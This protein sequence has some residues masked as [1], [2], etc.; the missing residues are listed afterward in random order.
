[1]AKT[2]VLA[3]AGHAH[4][5]ILANI[6]EI[7]KKGHQVLV[8]GPSPH[9]YYSGMGPGMLGGAYEPDDIRF[10]V[11]DMVESS[12]GVFLQ[13]QVARI[14]PRK[15][16]LLLKSGE[17]VD[18]DVVTFNTGSYV[19]SVAEE[20]SHN[21]F[22]VKPIENLSLGR[23]RILD[24][25]RDRQVRIGVVGGGPAGL[26][27]AGNSW[28]ASHENNGKG[29]SIR[30]YAGSR[31]MKDQ[32]DGVRSTALK[33]YAKRSI[34]IIEGVYVRKVD[35]GRVHLENGQSV[36]EDLI[37]LC[38]GVRPY[39]LFEPSGIPAGPDGGLLVN[40][41]LQSPEFPD[42]FGG[43]DCI[44]FSEEPLD[45]VG[46]YA[47]REHPVLYNNVVAR[48]EERELQPFGPGGGYLLIFNLGGNKG[49]L[50]RKG[51]VFNGRAAFQIKDYID[52]KFMRTFKP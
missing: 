31:F 51:V 37:F 17:R 30:V 39:P 49:I 19:P 18:Y 26:E 45:K 22:T 32:P 40:K 48:L 9:H 8:V 7:R 23:D 36:E 25:S 6:E 3:G 1:M 38:L 14:D 2:L 28:A 42:I 47:V 43:G 33:E 20:Q 24:L 15:K 4:M 44:Y 50:H 35:T 12:D 16:N 52:R 46:V 13:D 21:V 5:T 27:V 41:Y 29:A 11:K 34:D 10:P